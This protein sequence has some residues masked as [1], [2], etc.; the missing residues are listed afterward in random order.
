MDSRE[1]RRP[2]H[3]LE[4]VERQVGDEVAVRV[5]DVDL[6]GGGAEEEVA[7]VGRPLHVRQVARLDLLPP[8]PVPVVRS[9]DDHAIL[10]H[11]AD[12]APVGRPLHAAHSRLVPVVDHLFVPVRQRGPR[13]GAPK[14]RLL[15]SPRPNSLPS[16]RRQ[17]A[18]HCPLCNIHT[19]MRP[20][21]SAVVSLRWFSFQQTQRTMPSCPSRVWFI[22]R[23]LGA[24]DAFARSA[25]LEES[26]LSTYASPGGSTG[27]VI[28][29]GIF[30]GLPVVGNQSTAVFS[31]PYCV[32]RAGRARLE[33]PFLTATADPTAETVPVEAGQPC[34]VGNRYL[35]GQVDV[36]AEREVEPRRR[37]DDATADV[38]RRVFFFAWRR[39]K[40]CRPAGLPLPTY[41]PILLMGN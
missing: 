41:L 15:S 21:W 4:A 2:S 26:S 16:R 22:E 20:F 7:A 27:A 31:G 17:R 35:L 36:H 28:M 38:S 19:M 5:V 37:V 10:V 3:R 34:S 6:A 40:F 24:P 8:E 32:C 33:Q 25:A 11:D 23:L 18:H 30:W 29:S 14:S 9:D 39:R 12:A 13:G 1:C